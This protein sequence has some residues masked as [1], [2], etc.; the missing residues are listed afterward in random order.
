VRLRTLGLLG[1]VSGILTLVV[2]AL[3]S[4]PW[5]SLGSAD[6]LVLSVAASL[7]GGS[8]FLWSAVWTHVARKHTT[9]VNRSTALGVSMA[10]MVG[11]LTPLNVGTDVLRSVY[12]KRSLGMDYPLTAAASVVTRT[13]R[14]HV[15]LTFSALALA[16]AL[17]FPLNLVKY[18]V[19]SILVTLL[20]LAAFYSLRTQASGR[21]S[22]RLGIGDIAVPIAASLTKLGHIER[23]MIY[24]VFTVG[25]T[26]EWLSLHLCLLGLGV[27]MPVA[28]TL[29]LFTL[30]YFLSRSV[31]TPQGFGAVEASGAAVLSTTNL[32]VGEV[33]AFL[34][35]WDCVRVGVPVGL[36]LV[37]SLGMPGFG[38]ASEGRSAFRFGVRRGRSRR[39]A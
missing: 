39:T 33:G 35:A 13:L 38:K 36:A 18:L 8:C 24:V 15:T 12:G 23:G 20:L 14:L 11:M 2:I 3:I 26:L 30:L 31:P 5:Q 25:F 22:A 37:F 34:V 19:L 28:D 4:N 7:Y 27:M 32:G 21:L 6:L 29:V 16:T 9:G 1:V 17:L 10:S